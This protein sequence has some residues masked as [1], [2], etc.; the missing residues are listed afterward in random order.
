MHDHEE[1]P[2]TMVSGIAKLWK[3]VLK[4]DDKTLMI[5]TD[6]TRPGVIA[7]LEDFKMQVEE[8]Q[9]YD[10]SGAIKFKYK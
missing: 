8:I 7:L 2:T 5:D 10:D 4:K 3:A 9:T 6:F 1:P